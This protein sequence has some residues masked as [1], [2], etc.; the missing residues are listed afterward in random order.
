MP[1]RSG[2][3]RSTSRASPTPRLLHHIQAVLAI[4]ATSRSAQPAKQPA[5]GRAERRRR[6]H[7]A[8]GQRLLD[9]L[10]EALRAPDRGGERFWAALRWGGCGMVVVQLLGR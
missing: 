9:P 6:Q 4:A 2:R 7:L 8:L 1:S 10:P 5:L 3:G